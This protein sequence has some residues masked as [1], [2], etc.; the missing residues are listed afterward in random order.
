MKV[1]VRGIHLV[2]VVWLVGHYS[3]GQI[4]LAD[5]ITNV[6]QF[7]HPNLKVADSLI[8]FG[9][10]DGAFTLY[11]TA[12]ES[13]KKDNNLLGIIKCNNMIALENQHDFNLDSAIVILLDNIEFAHQN[14]LYQHPEIANSYFI[15]GQTYDFKGK[16]EEALEQHNKAL[17][18]RK[19]FYGKVHEDIAISYNGIAEVYL[20][21]KNDHFNAEKYLYLSLDHWEQLN[22][23]NSR[24]LARTYYNLAS[25]NRIHEDYEKALI[26]ANQSMQVYGQLK[27]DNERY[28]S[29]CY[30]LLANI[31]H[32]KKDYQNAIK[33]NLQAIAFSKS[34]P[35]KDAQDYVHYANHYKNLG[36]V[37]TD[38][39]ITDTANFYF[40]TALEVY[41]KIKSPLEISS[42]YL[43]IGYNYLQQKKSDSARLF[44]NRALELRKELFGNHHSSVSHALRFIGDSYMLQ[45]QNDLSRSNIETA[46]SYYQDAI[47]ATNVDFD[48]GHNVELNPSPE[49]MFVDDALFLALIEKG[50]SLKQ[51][52]ALKEEINYLQAANETYSLALQ[53]L[54][55]NRLSFE[56]EGSKL[57]LA[58]S[59]HSLAEKMLDCLWLL[60]QE[61]NE[62]ELYENVFELMENTKS[63]LILETFNKIQIISNAGIPDS[64]ISLEN[65]L[66][67]NLAFLNSQLENRMGADS[68]S[69]EIV[70]LRAKIF[71]N[72]RLQE[73]LKDSLKIYYPSYYQIRYETD[74]GF[75]QILLTLN[76]SNSQLLEYFWGEKAV[77]ILALGEINKFKKIPLD[78][79]EK[80]IITYY[81][82]ISKGPTFGNGKEQLERYKSSALNV[83]KH[84]LSD[85][86]SQ[87][88]QKLIIIPDGILRTIPFEALISSPVGESASYR[89]LPYVLNDFQFTYSYSANLWAREYESS[90]SDPVVL[91]F[92]YS[93]DSEEV[94]EMQG[95]SYLKG[96][97]EEIELISQHMKT[98]E[99]TGSNATE[100]NFKKSAGA[101]D[102]IHLAIHGLS[103]SLIRHNNRLLFNS[104]GSQEDGNLYGYEIYDLDINPKLV[105]LSSCESGM[106][107]E[108]KGDGV[109]GIARGFTYTGCPNIIISLWKV[110][111][112]ASPKVMS[113]FYRQLARGNPIEESLHQAKLEFIRKASNA[114]AH[115]VNWAPFIHIG[116]NNYTIVKTNLNTLLV[117]FGI[118]IIILA[119]I[120]GRRWYISQHLPRDSNN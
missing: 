60:K 54:E 23:Q 112:R 59:Y 69:G 73:Q 38:L 49:S 98:V 4:A 90:K 104:H 13:F 88:T 17:E 87:R 44:L 81:R 108:F 28:L 10:F 70:S 52:Y 63:Q 3:F 105:V 78:E 8:E 29:N 21:T 84:L 16:L 26:Y 41:N 93:S 51:K 120:M 15:L 99:F 43:S 45:H 61:V 79:L 2:L 109:Y 117:A 65:D 39:G 89:D 64:L 86:T 37:Y 71:D 80:S 76:K 46:L 95:V 9:D 106:G 66:K 91:G 57:F 40:Q 50:N 102:I 107:K 33:L 85:F 42:C 32:E 1:L 11:R 47:S 111:D 35:V 82:Q 58:E 12:L 6:Q 74:I 72:T 96:S 19:E 20:F 118:L 14:E 113:E 5:D 34:N 62:I 18:M 30:S 56:Q 27:Y 24:D 36:V 77:Y 110:I 53:I 103:D 7:D 55:L 115:P 119:G 100:E 75:D 67:A 116:S 92:A 22:I 48:I 101:Y 31:Y 83:Y 114:E 94:R 68:V 25:A 97:Y